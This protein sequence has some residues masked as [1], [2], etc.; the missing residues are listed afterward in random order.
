[1]LGNFTFWQEVQPDST[2]WELIVET[3]KGGIPVLAP[4]I[5]TL[6]SVIGLAATYKHPSLTK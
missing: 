5:L 2:S 3:F 1:M 4:G 6:G